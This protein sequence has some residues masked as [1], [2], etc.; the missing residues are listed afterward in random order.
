MSNIEHI[1]DNLS[2]EEIIELSRKLKDKQQSAEEERAIKVFLQIEKILQDNDMDSKEFKE[3]NAIRI[4]VN[5]LRNRKYTDGN[6][7]YWSG[8]GKRPQWV[9]DAVGADG[10]PSPLSYEEKGVKPLNERF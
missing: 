2:A 5:S 10:D 4:K 3:L 6:G 8:R 7:N 1:I 9:I